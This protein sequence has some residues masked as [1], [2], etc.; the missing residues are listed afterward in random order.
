MSMTISNNRVLELAAAIAPI[1][2]EEAQ[3][4]GGTDY[5]MIRDALERIGSHVT[6]MSAIKRIDSAICNYFC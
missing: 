5:H 1:V 6:S 2:R 3:V 4:R